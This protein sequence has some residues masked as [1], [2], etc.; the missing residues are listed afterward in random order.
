MS[1]GASDRRIRAK[2][3]GVTN[4][5]DA[6][7]A[8]RAGADALG[9]NLY[10][11]SKRFIRLED[12]LAWIRRLPPFVQRVAVLVNP[13][14]EEVEHVLEESGI[15]VVQFHGDETPE[16]CAQF[17]ARGVPFLKAVSAR[18]RQSL[19]HLD[20]FG[21]TGV[22]LDAYVPGEFGGTGR[23]ID[24]ELAAECVAV[25]PGTPII[26]SGGLDPT[27]VAEA[28][29]RVKPYAVDVAS[30]VE[31]GHDPRRKDAGRVQAFL[32]AVRRVV[33]R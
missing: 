13:T 29:A 6:L 22:L 16:F 8:I 9:F 30:G 25:N 2:I 24:L 14:P 23:L 26:L 19:E 21:A 17:A 10:P 33:L 28:A 7:V 27:N 15:D 3:C 1:G 18:D 20:R 4:H 32:G 11:K 5:E 12:S 31:S